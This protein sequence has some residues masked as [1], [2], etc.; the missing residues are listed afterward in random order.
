MKHACQKAS[1]LASDSIDRKL[2]LRERLQFHLH[3]MMCKNCNSYDKS[4]H[5][6]RSTTK[7]IRE[8]NYGETRLSKE[9]RKQLH[10]AIER[11]LEK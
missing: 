9:Q 3:L 5:L 4:L 2:T 7:L 11:H 10:S 1:R 8:T 6:I